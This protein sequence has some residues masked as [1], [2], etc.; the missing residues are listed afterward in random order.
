MHNISIYLHKIVTVLGYQI[1]R[2]NISC[3]NLDKAFRK[4][5]SVLTD[6][7]S[8]LLQCLLKFTESLT[9]QVSKNK[10]WC[11]FSIVS[12]LS[13]TEELFRMG[14]LSKCILVQP[15]IS[16]NNKISN[17]IFLTNIFLFSHLIIT[18]IFTTPY[19][20]SM[21]RLNT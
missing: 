9:S 11:H 4:D 10:L 17:F 8:L 14:P 2:F 16:I 18:N 5:I 3:G 6:S 12:L 15:H 13:D 21:G 7:H 19:L 20:S 1:G